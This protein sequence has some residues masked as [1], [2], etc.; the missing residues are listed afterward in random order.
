MSNMPTKTTIK[1]WVKAKK[2]NAMESFQRVRKAEVLATLLGTETESNAQEWDECVSKMKV[3]HNEMNDA[4]GYTSGFSYSRG[5]YLTSIVESKVKQIYGKEFESLKSE[6]DKILRNIDRLNSPKQML[7]YLKTCEMEYPLTAEVKENP[8][9]V[10]VDVM[11]Y[12][13]WIQ[14]QLT[15]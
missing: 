15:E 13:P 9:F 8:N 11:V 7:E 5:D 12:K 3:L 10:E 6:F 4:K 2:W 1:E 14:N